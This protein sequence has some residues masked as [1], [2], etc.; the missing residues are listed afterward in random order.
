MSGILI[1]PA[2]PGDAG[3]LVELARA[4]GGEPGGWLLADSNWRS[5]GDE[6]RFVRAVRKHRDAAV[7]VAEANEEIVGRLS[8]SR[9]PHPSS[10]HVADL[11]LMVSESHRRRGIGTALLE[12]AEQ[13]ARSAHVSKLE[14]H[15][16]PHNEP[17][18]A[19]YEH[20]GYA[21]EGFRLR[22]YRRPDGTLV[23]AVL[24]AKH[25]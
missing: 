10:A 9:D 13:W 3:A 4:V 14:L 20:C 25:L 22:H 7:L 17:A 15:V 12:A 8:L 5:V 11:G 19:L 1:R 6:R 23:D 24:M 2:E 16:F 21:R 18:I